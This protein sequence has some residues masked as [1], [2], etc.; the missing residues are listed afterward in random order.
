LHSSIRIDVEARGMRHLL[1]EASRPSACLLLAVPFACLA[2]EPEGTDAVGDAPADGPAEPAPATWV[3][4]VVSADGCRR[5]GNAFVETDDGGII[6]AGYLD[7]EGSGGGCRAWTMRLAADGTV[8]WEQVFGVGGEWAAGMAPHPDGGVLV[9]GRAAEGSGSH[10]WLLHLA[11]D[12][13][14]LWQRTLEGDADAGAYAVAAA[15]DGGFLLAGHAG[16]PGEAGLGIWVAR[17]DADG[18]PTW[19]ERFPGTATYWT[20]RNCVAEAPG[21]DVILAGRTDVGAESRIWLA[22]LDPA[23]SPRWQRIV[24]PDGGLAGGPYPSVAATSDGDA[25]VVAPWGGERGIQVL[26]FDATGNLRWQEAIAFATDGVRARGG[27]AAATRGGG[28]VVAG[29]QDMAAGAPYDLWVFGLDSSGTLLW[30]KTVV[31]RTLEEAH[32]IAATRDGAVV[33]MAGG[34]ADTWIA[35]LGLDGS[36]PPGC[37]VLRD[38]SAVVRLSA[39][40]VDQSSI[41]PVPTGYELRDE[42]AVAAPSASV[43]ESTCSD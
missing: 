37:A 13:R 12:G 36:S 14:A 7:H 29:T 1:P 17:T 43:V 30:Q 41:V 6:F 22:R 40:T 23:G 35:K 42:S 38:T 28:V 8:V 19:Q 26:R 32:A 31:A 25:V 15:A 21:G 10:V 18:R 3:R 4:H 20:Q 16:Y 2:V 27:V 9:A 5:Y 39:A 11:P 33:T 24:V 34:C